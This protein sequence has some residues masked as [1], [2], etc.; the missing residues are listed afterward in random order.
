VLPHLKIAK[1]KFHEI[2]QIPENQMLLKSDRTK[3][4]ENGKFWQRLAPRIN[5]EL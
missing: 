5:D 1:V 4:A 3:T 2:L